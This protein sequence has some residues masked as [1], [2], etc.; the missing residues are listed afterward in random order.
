MVYNNINKNKLTNLLGGNDKVG[1]DSHPSRLSDN[2]HN[3]IELYKN[4]Q[5]I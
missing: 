1:F 3:N 5:F 2:V 4:K